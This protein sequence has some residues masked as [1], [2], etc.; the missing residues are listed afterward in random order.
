[1]RDN[2]CYFTDSKRKVKKRDLISMRRGN[3]FS[4]RMFIAPDSNALA[5]TLDEHCGAFSFIYTFHL[6]ETIHF[7]LS[8]IFRFDSISIFNSASINQYR[9]VSFRLSPLYAIYFLPMSIYDSVYESFY[10][11]LLN[12]EF[13]RN[14]FGRSVYTCWN[15]LTS[16][17]GKRFDRRPLKI[18]NRKFVKHEDIDPINWKYFKVVLSKFSIKMNR[19]VYISQLQALHYL[20]EKDA[21]SDICVN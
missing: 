20:Y 15:L 21:I 9:F 11:T 1:M 6:S 7:I 12:P 13:T 5:R 14:R 2:R 4:R 19:A 8:E 17:H 18:L 3:I 10:F 16:R